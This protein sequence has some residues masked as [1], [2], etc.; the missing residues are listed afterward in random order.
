MN[1]IIPILASYDD[2]KTSENRYVRNNV[3]E[4]LYKEI[5]HLALTGNEIG[6]FHFNPSLGKVGNA[7]L[8]IQSPNEQILREFMNLIVKVLHDEDTISEFRN[9]EVKK[10]EVE[11]KV[12][13]FKRELQN[14]VNHI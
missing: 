4:G 8:F 6:L 11:S 13:D 12:L 2:C 9:A 10:T 5:E 14:V 7:F 3:I 1:R